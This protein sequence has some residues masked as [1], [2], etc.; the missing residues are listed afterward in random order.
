M[1]DYYVIKKALAYLFINQKDDD[2]S[3]LSD[4]DLIIK[5]PSGDSSKDIVIRNEIIRNA[6]DKATELK[7]NQFFTSTNHSAELA[8]Q[9][10]GRFSR[11]FDETEVT[12]SVNG[13]KYQ[14]SPASMEYCIYVISMICEN[15]EI[16]YFRTFQDFRLNFHLAYRRATL[17]NNFDFEKIL[18]KTLRLI[19]LKM[20]FENETPVVQM[21]KYASAFE[22]LFMYKRG[23]ALFEISNIS[24]LL[25][26]EGGGRSRVSSLEEAPKRTVNPEVLEYYSMALATEDPFTM[27][28]SFYHIVEYFFDEIYQKKLIDDMKDKI[29]SPDFSYK[30]EKKLLE[31]ASF[32]NNRM[33]SDDEAGKGNEFESLKY[34]LETYAPVEELKNKLNE[35]NPN[36]VQFY[37]DN[38][39]SFVGKQHLKIAWN[40]LAGVYS[41]L[42]KRI[43]ATRNALVH[44]KSG[45]NDKLYKPLKHKSILI[46]ELPLIQVIAEM[47]INKSG[48]VL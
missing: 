4:E 28:I 39:V 26:I 36:L 19:T 23:Y 42:A 6:Y 10:A 35:I 2:T 7:S 30:N 31:L 25:R 47:I 16:D 41:L 40:D 12:D 5:A 21:K 37:S 27:Y 22:Y 1:V 45:Q 8:V 46:K 24:T 44:S 17:E 18:P 3:E 48:E 43:Y 29:T 13:I 14:L 34:V 20:Q 38:S 33:K 9:P 32:I 15:Q 11:S